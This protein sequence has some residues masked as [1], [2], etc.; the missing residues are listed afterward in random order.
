MTDDLG[1]SESSPGEV[2]R[3]MEVLWWTVSC[4]FWM[5]IQLRPIV[6]R[7]QVEDCV[8]LVPEE[9]YL[10]SQTPCSAAVVAER[11]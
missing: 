2:L 10:L 8:I 5:H 1:K 9:A 7:S 11:N 4:L 6:G 3:S